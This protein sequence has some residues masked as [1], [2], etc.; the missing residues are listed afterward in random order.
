MKFLSLFVCVAVVSFTTGC[1]L[2]LPA[3]V[4]NSNAT[5]AENPLKGGSITMAGKSQKLPIEGEKACTVWPIEDHVE[6]TATDG[7][8]CARGTIHLLK[9]PGDPINDNGYLFESDGS[10]DELR[11]DRLA[12]A[13]P[14]KIG[15]CVDGSG[16]K[17]VW[18]ARVDGC[19]PNTDR[20]KPVLTLRSTF[21]LVIDS[22]GE[23]RWKFPAADGKET[24]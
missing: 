15:S 18:A 8:I 5:R 1:R 17:N 20:G 7:Q 10:G 14:H 19:I 6:I 2:L 4:L 12:S 16:A 24:K 11:T 9:N 3:S 22:Y 23:K 21:L 13:S